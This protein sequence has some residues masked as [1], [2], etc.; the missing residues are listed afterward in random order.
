MHTEYVEFHA[1]DHVLLQGLLYEPSPA[2]SPKWVLHVHGLAGSFYENAFVHEIGR[3]L[4]G[5]GISFL[6]FNNRGHDYISDL[7]IETA[8]GVRWAKGGG[9]HERFADC[10]HDILGVID[11]ARSRGAQVVVLEG[12]SSGANKVTFGLGVA[13]I[14]EVAGAILLSPCDDI[15]LM[16]R[17]RGD[18]WQDD[19]RE[20]EA[21]VAR[22]EG[23]RIIP[24][25][26]FGDYPVSAATYLADFH[27]GSDMDI[28]P[29]RDSRSAFGALAAITCPILAVF[30]N[31]GELLDQEPTGALATL[32]SKA[33]RSAR[34]EG[35]IVDGAPHSYLGKESELARAISDWASG[36]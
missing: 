33:V 9:A 17:E 29:Y 4:T 7:K 18:S 27:P 23:D 3:A 1:R 25:S 2:G 14:G 10:L 21:M 13:R 22:G 15:G 30:G 6:S 28:F 32:R 19:F 20:A 16:L 8:D 5:R 35:R 24:R 34:F 11:F 26:V 36:L 31:K 12:H